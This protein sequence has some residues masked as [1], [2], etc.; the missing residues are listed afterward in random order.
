M[1]K[2]LLKH[3]KNKSTSVAIFRVSVTYKT[4][5]R[6]RPRSI[7]YVYIKLLYVSMWV[8]RGKDIDRVIPERVVSN[9]IHKAGVLKSAKLA[10][11]NI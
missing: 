11:I 6:R 10:F 7:Y 4:Q 8:R 3:V 1:L 9:D 2:L 5:S